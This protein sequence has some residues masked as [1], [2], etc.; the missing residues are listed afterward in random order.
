MP[1]QNGEVVIHAWNYHN[2]V[3]PVVNGDQMS[4]GLIPRNYCTHPRGFYPSIQAVDIP[5]ID[6]SEWS[7]RIKD[8]EA[9]KSRLSDMR[10]QGSFWI[11]CI[12]QNGKGYCWA[13]SGTT[14]SIMLRAAGNQPYV[15]LSAYAV[16]CVIKSY[17]DEGGWGAQGVDFIAERGVPSGQFWPQQSMS[18]A[19][20]KPETWENAALHKITEGWIDLAAAQYDRKLSFAQMMTCLL[21]RIPVVT[22]FNWWSHSVCA[23]DPA[24][25]NA[26]DMRD[27]N[28]KVVAWSS[29][30]PMEKEAFDMTGGFCPRIMNSWSDSWSDKG[31]GLLLG[32]KGIPDGAVAPRVTGASTS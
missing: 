27:D 20:D 31:M 11:P 32:S 26:G 3:D 14:A 19:N 13:H 22:D 12:D 7:E 6:Q 24:E 2:H 4:R 18:K 21:S 23:I 15:P 17:R 8:M 30:P 9:S 10:Q 16:A 28:G 25:G 5:L 1:A 29:L